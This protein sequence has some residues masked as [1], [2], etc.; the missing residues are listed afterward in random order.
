MVFSKFKLD[1]EMS[2]FRGVVELLVE[3][4]DRTFYNVLFDDGNH[5]KKFPRS[6]LKLRVP[7]K[8]KQYPGNKNLSKK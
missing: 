7:R 5:E 2:W 6:V 4:K 1:G 3:G 8:D